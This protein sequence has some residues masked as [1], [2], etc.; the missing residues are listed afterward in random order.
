MTAVASRI[1]L[2]PYLRLVCEFPLRPFRNDNAYERGLR[3]LRS[4]QSRTDR[5]TVD[6]KKILVALLAEYEKEAGWHI[7][8]SHVTAADI[9][10]H[11]LDDR[12][13]S[14]NTL[15]KTV[16]ISQSSL[17]EMLSGRRDWSK[18]AIAKLSDYFGLNPGVFFIKKRR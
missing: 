7:D 18:S 16:G 9:V 8:T 15:G 14:V 17:S 4:L 2:D 3:R 11:L 6:Y 10:R 1:K 13:M 5:A 12:E